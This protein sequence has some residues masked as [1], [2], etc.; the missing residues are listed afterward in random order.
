MTC[1][2]HNTKLS[3]ALWFG[4]TIRHPPAVNTNINTLSLFTNKLLR[5]PSHCRTSEL[6][7][8]WSPSEVEVQ[9]NTDGRFSEKQTNTV[10]NGQTSKQQQTNTYIL[11][12]GTTFSEVTTIN[13]TIIFGHQLDFRLKW[14]T[15]RNRLRRSSKERP[16]VR[17]SNF[18]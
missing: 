11:V 16:S 7:S 18:E 12:H 17:R 2:E 10:N 8:P 3:E 13:L 14:L 5:L 6:S 4:I 15:F 1:N 9:G